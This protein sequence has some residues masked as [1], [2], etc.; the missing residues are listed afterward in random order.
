MNDVDNN[1]LLTDYAKARIFDAEEHAKLITLNYNSLINKLI[2][3]YELDPTEIKNIDELFDKI[4]PKG[5]EGNGD[6]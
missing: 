5:T 2:E 6:S 1:V 4:L 3:A